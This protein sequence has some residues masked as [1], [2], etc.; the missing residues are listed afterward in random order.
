MKHDYGNVHA[1]TISIVGLFCLEAG[2][3]KLEKKNHLNDETSFIFC[4]SVV[5]L[6]ENSVLFLQCEYL[7]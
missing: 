2:Y 5:N 4:H 6:N 1:V 7:Q 3:C